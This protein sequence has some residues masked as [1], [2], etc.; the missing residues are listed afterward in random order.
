M[1]LL[2]AFIGFALGIAAV[3]FLLGVLI[4]IPSN[5]RAL[6]LRFVNP[7]VFVSTFLGFVWGF[8][9]M[10]DLHDFAHRMFSFL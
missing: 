5:L 10:V 1:G 2:G 4:L 8:T 3:G 7:V 6:F 9:G